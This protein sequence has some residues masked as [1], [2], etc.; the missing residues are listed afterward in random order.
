MTG[1]SGLVF[2]LC[3][4]TYLNQ[5]ALI[6]MVIKNHMTARQQTQLHEYFCLQDDSVMII[7][8]E[9]DEVLFNNE[10]AFQLFQ[11]AGSN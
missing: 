5:R 4:Y 10:A 2:M 7:D 11:S 9:T 1:F 8:P 3:V 6:T